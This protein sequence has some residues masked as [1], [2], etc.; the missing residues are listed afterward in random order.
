M[1]PKPDYYAAWT[2]R[3]SAPVLLLISVLALPLFIAIGLC[4]GVRQAVAAWWGEVRGIWG[5]TIEREP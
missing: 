1:K 5:V 3:L 4:V 2:Q